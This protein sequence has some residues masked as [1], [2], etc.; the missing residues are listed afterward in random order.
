MYHCHLHFYFAG[1]HCRAFEVIKETAPSAHFTHEFVW[2]ER[3]DEAFLSSADVIFANLQGEGADRELWKLASGKR[4]DAE[5]ILL[6]DEASSRWPVW[7][8]DEA[9]ALLAE[10]ADIWKLPMTDDEIRFRFLRWQR[11]CREKKDAWQTSHYLEATINNIP[12]LIWYKDKDGIQDEG[13]GGGPRPRL[14]L[15]RGGGRSGLYRVGTDRDDEAGDLHIGG[16]C[17]DR[18]RDKASDYL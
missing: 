8:A 5:L 18:G 4:R 3:A 2:S 14:Y 11:A 15:G 10:I 1:Q 12:N 16:V 9:G 13:A 7:S 6:T 17:P